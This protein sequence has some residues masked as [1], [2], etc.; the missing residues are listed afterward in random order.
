MTVMAGPTWQGLNQAYY[1]K[2]HPQDW[3]V[4]SGMLEYVLQEFK[5]CAP[6]DGMYLVVIPSLRQ[7][8]PERMA[9]PADLLQLSPDDAACDERVCDLVLELCRRLE[10]RAIDMRPV[11]RAYAGELYWDTDQHINMEGH[12][13]IAE[14]LERRLQSPVERNELRS[15]WWR[16]AAPPAIPAGRLRRSPAAIGP[17]LS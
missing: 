6:H 14:E 11:F 1:F 4:A 3:D 5:S 12:R 13:L 7:L 2:H 9:A 10:I 16:P 17:T 8:H 15:T